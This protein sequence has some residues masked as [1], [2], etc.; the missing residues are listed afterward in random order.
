MPSLYV[1][2]S[3][4]EHNFTMGQVYVGSKFPLR[5]CHYTCEE[6][7]YHCVLV[8]LLPMHHII[9]NMQLPTILLNFRDIILL[10]NNSAT[11]S[12]WPS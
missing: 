11:T 12:K 4:H 8:S 10:F 2:R 9:P 1:V 6:L 3:L 5:I 7:G